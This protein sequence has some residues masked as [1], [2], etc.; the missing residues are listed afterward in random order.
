M[1][2]SIDPKT[3][4]TPMWAMAVFRS[5]RCLELMLRKPILASGHMLP[6][7]QAGHMKA[8]DPIRLLLK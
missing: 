4:D 5:S 1:E 7:K 2:R 3:R 8:S 6:R